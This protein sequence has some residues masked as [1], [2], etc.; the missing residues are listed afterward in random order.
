MM[1]R[2]KNHFSYQSY[3]RETTPLILH[4]VIL[5]KGAYSNII[6]CSLQIVTQSN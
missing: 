2:E 5:S 3:Q 6:D 4:E 1:S